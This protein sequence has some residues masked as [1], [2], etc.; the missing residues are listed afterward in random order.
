[1]PILTEVS[2]TIKFGDISDKTMQEKVDERTGLS[3]RVIIDFRDPNVRPRVSIK[4]DNGRTAKL[5]NGLDARYTLPVGAHINVAEGMQVEAGDVLSRSHAKQQRR[6]T[7][8]AA[9]PGWPNCL[10]PASPRSL[11][12]SVRLRAK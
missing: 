12:S 8:R 4:D 7:L 6:K 1:M 2:G 11:L 9:C 5:S 3:T 10:K